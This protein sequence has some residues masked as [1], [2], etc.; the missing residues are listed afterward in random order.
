MI[1]FSKV[2]WS[3]QRS[4]KIEKFTGPFNLIC[5][6]LMTNFDVTGIKSET[7][8]DKKVLQATFQ[9]SWF[10]FE[11]IL[12]SL[13]FNWQQKCNLYFNND[14]NTIIY[15]IL[16]N[17]SF[18]RLPKISWKV[19]KSVCSRRVRDLSFAMECFTIYVYFI[20]SLHS[21]LKLRS[22]WKVCQ[23]INWFS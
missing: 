16:F 6:F 4:I 12:A 2:G 3:K 7:C 14:S 22:F 11:F 13:K 18:L 21:H 23:T 19:Y 9:A 20:H 1:L 15:A 5:V 17:Y 8:L 10:K